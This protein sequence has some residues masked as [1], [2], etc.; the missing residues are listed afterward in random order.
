MVNIICVLMLVACTNTNESLTQYSKI[1]K[2]TKNYNSLEM[3]YNSL[4]MGD[5]R[6]KIENLLGEPD[7]SPIEGLYYYS[8]D[9]ESYSDEQQRYVPVG[10]VLDYRGQDGIITNTLQKYSIGIIEE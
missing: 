4:N 10:V 2:K 1:Y 6:D 8:S 7:Y 3:I 5:N 9:K